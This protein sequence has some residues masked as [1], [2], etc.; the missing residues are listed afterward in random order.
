MITTASVSLLGDPP[1]PSILISAIRGR[2]QRISG[3]VRPSQGWCIRSPLSH[4]TAPASTSGMS[5]PAHRIRYAS[6]NRKRGSSWRKKSSARQGGERPT[7]ITEVPNDPW[8]FRN[9]NDSDRFEVRRTADHHLVMVVG[10][11]DR[12][13][14]CFRCAPLP[15]GGSWQHAVSDFKTGV[16]MRDTGRGQRVSAGRIPDDSRTNV[17]QLAG[18]IAGA[19]CSQRRGRI[20]PSDRKLRR[21]DGPRERPT[22]LSVPYQMRSLRAELGEPTKTLSSVRDR[23]GT[24]E[25]L[26]YRFRDGTV[27]LSVTYDLAGAWIKRTDVRR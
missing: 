8:E 26:E 9:I 25:V 24:H 27:L 3:R 22:D 17:V 1:R 15:V 20:S 18:D 7:A 14:R 21:A 4:W 13:N 10:K 23:R 2:H 5:I 16:E 11:S 19:A 6:T 12:A